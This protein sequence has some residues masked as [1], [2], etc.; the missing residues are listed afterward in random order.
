MVLTAQKSIDTRAQEHGALERKPNILVVCLLSILSGAVLALSA[1]GFDQWYL[2]WIGFVPLLFLSCSSSGFKDVFFRGLLFGLGY[3]MVYLNWVFGLH[4][5]DWLG[6]APWQSSLLCLSALS[7]WAGHQALLVSLFCVI[8]RLIPVSGS[9]FPQKLRNRWHVP[10]AIVIP[11]VWVLW[12]GKIGNAHSLCGVPWGMLEYSQYKQF[13]VIQ[14]ASMIGGI[15]IGFIIAAFNVSLASLIATFT[16]NRNFRPLA[17][18]SRKIAVCQF[19][20]LNAAIFAAFGCSYLSIKDVGWPATQT[21]SMLQTNINFNMFFSKHKV[22]NPTDIP[23]LNMISRC[24]P[25]LCLGPENT[26]PYDFYSIPSVCN[27][28]A[29]TAKKRKLDIV[30]STLHAKE[31]STFPAK[32]FLV[33]QNP[34]S[35]HCNSAFAIDSDGRPLREI[36]HKRFLVP[37]SEYSPA[38][39]QLVKSFLSLPSAWKVKSLASGRTPEVFKL[40]CGSIAPLICVECISPEL[41]CE[42]VKAGGNL[43]VTLGDPS[44]LHDSM[45]GKQMIAMLVMRAVENRR[46]VAFSCSTGPS[47]IIDPAGRIVLQSNQGKE[48]LVTGKVGFNS[49]L[50]P[51]CRWFSTLARF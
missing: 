22:L 7:I 38:F 44:F 49:E 41:A 28:I 39:Y 46:Y 19:G 15:G 16:G 27:S 23:F 36:Y 31:N 13:F 9:F 37:I 12:M 18:S 48:E 1:P 11:A 4:P 47:A 5:L 50:T 6:F 26:F 25:G 45:V 21:V 24:P 35:A 17:C 3:E 14:I 43:L 30:L 2:A 51:F 8:C 29:E 20:V 10:A 40:S 33:A 34:K 32:T 42:S